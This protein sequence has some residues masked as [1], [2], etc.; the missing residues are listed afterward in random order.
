MQVLTGSGDRFVIHDCII[1]S[2]IM[3][4]LLILNPKDTSEIPSTGTE[5]HFLSINLFIL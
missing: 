3:I 4:G 5:E 2:L 1:V